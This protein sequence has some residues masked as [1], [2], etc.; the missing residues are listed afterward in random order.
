M[1]SEYAGT[2]SQGVSAPESEAGGVY[3]ELTALAS[4]V[5]QAGNFA[6]SL[7]RRLE[8]VLGAGSPMASEPTSIHE[9]SNTPLQGIISSRLGEMRAL[10]S[11]LSSLLER[12]D[13]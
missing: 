11:R 10:N 8:P 1:A 3:R 6:S 5:E 2:A 9:A 13:I 12:I 7:E 4:A